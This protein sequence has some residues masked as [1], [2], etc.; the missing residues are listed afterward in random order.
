MAV[1]KPSPSTGMDPAQAGAG[2]RSRF[3]AIYDAHA[4]SVYQYLLSRLGNQ[5]EAR[6]LT[7]QTVLAAWEHFPRSGRAAAPVPG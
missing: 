1:E 2:E 7:S 6:D 3:L 5:E 4:P